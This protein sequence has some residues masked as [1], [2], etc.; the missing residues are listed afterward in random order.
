MKRE[1]EGEKVGGQVLLVV[2]RRLGRK[3]VL[4]KPVDKKAVLVV[5]KKVSGGWVGAYSHV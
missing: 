1:V 5:L 4:C 2:D 3:I